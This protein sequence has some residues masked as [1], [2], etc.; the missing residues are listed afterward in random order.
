M[1]ARGGWPENK[2]PKVKTQTSPSHGAALWMPV[3]LG[4]CRVRGKCVVLETQY[5]SVSKTFSWNFFFL[6]KFFLKKWICSNLN[7]SQIKK[8][9]IYKSV[10]CE[11]SYSASPSAVENCFFPKVLVTP[12]SDPYSFF[13]LNLPVSFNKTS[14]HLNALKVLY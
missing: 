4:S 11:A 12:W 1:P 6:K 14:P 3:P 10:N 8:K 2:K 7:L 5:V 13:P 9:N